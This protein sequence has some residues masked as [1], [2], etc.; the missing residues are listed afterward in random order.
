LPP[1]KSQLS[2]ADI[3]ASAT[4]ASVLLVGKLMKKKAAAFSLL[5]LLLLLL[6]S[7]LPLKQL[8]KGYSIEK[9]S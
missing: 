1:Q 9:E 7:S 2:E 3:Q 5:L 6:S 4:S 8:Q